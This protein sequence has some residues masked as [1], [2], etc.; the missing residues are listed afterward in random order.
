MNRR[1][2]VVASEKKA[3]AA[4][5]ENENDNDKNIWN[6]KKIESIHVKVTYRV[7]LGG[8]EV[9][10]ET[11]NALLEVA[12]SG[13]S[14]DWSPRTDVENTAFEWLNANIRERD[15]CGLEYEIEDLAEQE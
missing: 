9:D 5:F 13:R 11:Y 8:I 2:V 1:R 4:L 7:G 14:I 10:D 6:M 15:C 12:D 3:R